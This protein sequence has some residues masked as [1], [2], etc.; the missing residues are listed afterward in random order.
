MYPIPTNEQERLLEL[1]RLQIL[2]TAPAEDFD[3]ILQVACQIS[4]AAQGT[5]TLVDANRQWFKARIGVASQETPRQEALCAHAIMSDEPLIIED[6]RD[7][8][9]FRD[10][11]AVTGCDKVR[12]YAG[13]PLLVRPG[14]ALGTLC[15]FD[16]QPRTLDPGVLDML[17]RLGV[18]AMSLLQ[19]WEERGQLLEMLRLVEDQRRDLKIRE[20]RFQHVE[21]LAR[22]GGFEMDL[23]S[24]AIQWTDEVYRI[25]GRP[26]GMLMDRTNIVSVYAPEEQPRVRARMAS[27]LE[28]A[29]GI[30]DV[31]RILTPEGQEKWVHVVSETEIVDGRAKRLFG[32]VQDVSER[33]QLEQELRTAACTD[34]LTGLA[35]RARFNQLVAEWFEA[36]DRPFGLLLVDLDHFKQIND[37]LGHAVGDE[38][39]RAVATRLMRQT[40][41]FGTAFRIGGDEF[42]V[43]VDRLDDTSDLG[44]V[45]AGLAAAMSAPIDVS[46]HVLCPRVTIGGAVARLDGTEA[47][48]LR[49]NAD[50]ALYHAKETKRGGFIQFHGTLR[51]SITKRFNV[52][53]EVHE[54]IDDGRILPYYQPIVRIDTSEIVGV[55]ALVRMRRKDGWIV[56]AGDFPEALADVHVS[57]LVTERMLGQVAA[58]MR[59][60]L[61]D[62]LDF[63]HVGINVG[64]TDFLDHDLERRVV[65]A[66]EAHRVPLRH[67]AIEVTENVLMGPGDSDVIAT[68]QSLRARGAVIALDDFGTGYASLTHLRTFPV[69]VIKIDKSFVGQ[70]LTDPSSAAIVE[71]VLD[72]AHKLSM[73]VVAEGIETS[74]QAHR[75]QR[76]G[77]TLGQGYRYARPVSAAATSALMTSFGKRQAPQFFGDCL[78]LDERVGAM[79]KA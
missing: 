46:G 73:R 25:T 3:A 63:H 77:C 78:P 27:S 65:M 11:P 18:V 41:G 69:D 26:I 10:H 1:H 75:L 51:T 44:V 61:D 31:F 45:A 34:L 47:E 17:R 4:G 40:V 7:H 59:R 71:L 64:V 79:G 54:A 57:R 60:W 58:D 68:L 48:T 36:N 23:T 6:A 21:R 14:V 35:N 22:V 33:Y 56:S 52:V 13:I 9:D 49:Q 67:V 53:R 55:E 66:F 2:D 8:P 39:L 37:T 5:V 38:L 72:L 43:L 15:V 74:E 76:L 32:I 24:G 50:L 28:S 12:F 19:R 16:P 29:T 30:D 42:A 70:M 62:G 20:R